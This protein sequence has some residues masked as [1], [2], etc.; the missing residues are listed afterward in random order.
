MELSGEITNLKNLY[1]LYWSK[2][3]S[4]FPSSESMRL[5]TKLGAHAGPS[6]VRDVLGEDF[7]QRSFKVTIVRNPYDAAVSRFF[8]RYRDH[9]PKGIESARQRFETFVK[10]RNNAP[11]NTE[12]PLNLDLFS[13]VIRYESLRVDLAAL[14]VHLE[15]PQEA[16]NAFPSAKTGIRPE[17][18][19]DYRNLYTIEARKA[20][21]ANY[22]SALESM[23]YT[24]N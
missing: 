10:Q 5:E 11:I 19:R 13:H 4:V 12:I 2:R 1:A 3:Y 20:V 18:A 17:W 16:I 9:Q 22:K 23:E 7:W 21:E 14:L 8:W 24:F 15:S 6:L